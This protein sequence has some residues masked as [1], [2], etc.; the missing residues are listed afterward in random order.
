MNRVIIIPHVHVL[1]ANALSSPI[2]VGFPAMTAWLGC[3]HALQRKL[4]RRPEFEKI[5]FSGVGVVS[6]SFTMKSYKDSGMYLNSLV[7][8]GIP[9][10]K[11]GGR[12]AFIEEARCDLE[13]SLIIEVKNFD[14]LLKN[15]LEN[16]LYELL[17]GGI[18]VAGGDILHLEKPM[19]VVL[20]DESKFN[21]FKKRLMPSFVL[22]ERRS[23]MAEAMVEGRDG[24]DALLEFLKVT[25]SCSETEPFVWKSSREAAGWIVPIATGYQGISHEIVSSFQRDRTTRHRFAESIVTLGEFVMPYRIKTLEEMLWS[26][27]F[28][29]ENDLYICINE[30]KKKEK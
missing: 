30:N 2:T 25:Y 3:V 6:H 24:I 22:L 29:S 11:K 16:L 17:L 15:K 5:S 4:I 26:Y 8:M 12:S 9:L 27:H 19:L 23:L 13:V 28:E 21:K 20:D 10:N 18:K 14:L 7:G 1:N